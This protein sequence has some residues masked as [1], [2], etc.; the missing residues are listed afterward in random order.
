MIRSRMRRSSAHVLLLTGIVTTILGPHCLVADDTDRP[1]NGAPLV[2]RDV[3]VYLLSAYGTQLNE[4]G[5]FS[6]TLPSY[7]LSRRPTAT[8]DSANQAT[9]AGILTFSGPPEK[10]VDVLMEF[11]KGRFLSHWPPGRLR[12]KRLLWASVDLTVDPTHKP[13][14]MADDHWLSPLRQTDRLYADGG[15]YSDRYLL[16]DVELPYAPHVTLQRTEGGYTVTNTGKYPIH[17]VVVYRPTES[18]GWE[19]AAAD[20]V[21]AAKKPVKKDDEA[22]KPKASPAGKAP[23]PQGQPRPAAEAPAA[24]EAAADAPVAVEAAAVAEAA[25]VAAVQKAAAAAE[26]NAAQAAG[27]AAD[28]KAPKKKQPTGASAEASALGIQTAAEALDS[29][30]QSLTRLDLQQP[31]IDFVQNVLT[32]QALRSDSAML[33]YRLDDAQLEALLPLEVTPYPDRLFRVALVVV[34]DADPDLQSEIDKLVAQLGDDQWR[35]REQ[36]QKDL[37]ELGLAAKPKLEGALK[38]KDVEI[39]FRAEQLL[40]AIKAKQ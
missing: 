1:A 21:D 5:L 37:A 8:R 14:A 16:Y 22:D 34:Q 28:E 18:N 26:Q 31:E 27:D 6:S 38:H 32:Q 12:S 35:Q 9:P 23:K 3:A 7:T 24:V 4:R 13:A 17:D 2:V 33:V 19:V 39:V 36:A 29:W 15:K 20:G 30:R 25:D 10:D 40:E 11:D